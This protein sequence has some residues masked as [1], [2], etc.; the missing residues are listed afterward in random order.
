MVTHFDDDMTR[1]GFYFSAALLHRPFH[2][3]VLRVA[4]EEKEPHFFRGRTHFFIIEPPHDGD[5]DVEA[6][7]AG[8]LNKSV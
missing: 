7:F 1:F 6:G 3:D 5:I 2:G 4:L 8:R